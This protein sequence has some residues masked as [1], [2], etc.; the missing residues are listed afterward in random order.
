MKSALP[1]V[2]HEVCG[3][4]MASYVIEAARGLNPARI[5]VIVGHKAGLVRE[6]LAAPGISFVDQSRQ[7]GTA[8]AVRQCREAAAGADEIVVLNGDSPFITAETLEALAAAR[9]EAPI[10]FLSCLVPDSGA[11]GRV[12]RNGEGIVT[13]IAEQNDGRGPALEAERNAGQYLF[14]AAWLWAHIDRVAAS[15]KG[16]YYLTDLVAVACAE[17]TP[18]VGLHASAE[19]LMGFDDRVGLAEAEAAMRR[20]IL[21]A[22]MLN[23]V[24]IIDPATTYIDASVKMEQDVTLLPNTTLGGSTFVASGV[25]LGPNA[26]LRNATVGRDTNIGPSVVEDSEIGEGVTIGPFCHIRGHSLIGDGSA[27]GNYA[28]VNRSR[29][30]RGVK[31]HHFSYLGDATVGDGANI[32]AGVITCNYDGVNKN[33][34]IIGAGAFVGCDTMLIAPIEMGPNSQTGAGTVLRENLA[35]NA[36][37]VGVPARIIGTRPVA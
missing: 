6:R 13:A 36:V 19:A 21:R 11:F 35:P 17:G 16:E 18:P 9:G 22:H 1:K 14:E 10:A 31:M 28:E 33:P 23:G 34:T 8:D 12:Q 25:R 7:L 37:A 4:P 29:L 3:L 15:P 27:L 20:R 30:G 24:T 26:V 32:A 5:I 2:L